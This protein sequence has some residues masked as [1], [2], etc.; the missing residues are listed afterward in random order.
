METCG[1]LAAEGSTLAHEDVV[2]CIKRV[3][4]HGG[5]ARRASSLQS[6]VRKKPEGG[7]ARLAQ[8]LRLI[9]L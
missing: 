4:R 9:E 3:Q 6:L 2:R 8:R 1:L 5:A 7:G